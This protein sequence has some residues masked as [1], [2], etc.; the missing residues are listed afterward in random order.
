[1]VLDA[2]LNA[3]GIHASTPMTRVITGALFGVSM[4]WF[5]V[6]IFIEACLQLNHRNKNHSPD[7]GAV[8]YDRKTQ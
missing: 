4:P 1:M 3:T 5:V 7:S 2:V 8:R 6:P